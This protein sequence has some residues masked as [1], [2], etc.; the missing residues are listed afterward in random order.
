MLAMSKSECIMGIQMYITIT[1][2]VIMFN[3]ATKKCITTLMI[4]EQHIRMLNFIIRIMFQITDLETFKEWQNP[5]QLK[6]QLNITYVN[7]LPVVT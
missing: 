7:A 3:M 2:I 6:M 5:L 4:T 1:V